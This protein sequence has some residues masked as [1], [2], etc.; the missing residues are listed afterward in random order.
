MSKYELF[1]DHWMFTTE[2]INTP[3][4]TVRKAAA[5]GGYTAAIEK[6]GENGEI[7]PLGQGGH[8]FLNLI[9]GGNEVRGLKMLAGTDFDAILAGWQSVTIPHDW[10]MT[11]PYV[12][13]PELLMSGSKPNG[14]AYYRKCF[15]LPKEYENKQIHVCFEGVMRAASVWLNGCFLGDHY[16]GYTGFSFD[17]SDLAH[18]GEEGDNILLVRVDTT[19]GS[20]GWWYDGAGI[21]RNVTLQVSEKLHIPQWGV[22]VRTEKLENEEAVVSIESTIVNKTYTQA[23]FQVKATLLHDGQVIGT[24]VSASETVASLEKIVLKQPVSIKHPKKWAIEKPNLYDVLVEVLVDHVVIDT[25]ETR[26]GLRTIDYTSEG[27]FINGVQTELKGVCEH[28]DFAGVGTALTKEIVRYK[29]ERLKEMGANAYRSAHHAA[30]IELLDLCDEMGILV[31]E[32][33]R[34]LESSDLRLLELEEMVIRD[35]NHPSIIFWSLCNEEVIGSTKMATRMAA[36]MAAVVRKLD[37]ERL[38]VSAEL[39]SPEGIVSE[40]YIQLF[41]VLGVN[42]PESPIMGNGLNEIHKRYPNQMVMSTENASFFSTRGIYQDD[43]DLCQTSNYGSCLSMFRK[44]PLPPDAPGAGGTAHPEQVMDFY[45][46]HPFMGGSFIWTAL[47]YCGEP[48]PFPW[49]AISSQFGIMDTCGFPKDYFYYYQSKWTKEPMVHIMPHWNFEGREGELI[50]I[51]VFTNCEAAELFVNDESQGIK[52][53]GHHSTSWEVPYASGE[54]N[55]IGYIQ[56]KEVV[57]QTK[58]TSGQ[59]VKLMAR[60]V[61][62]AVTVVADG[63]TAL[64]EIYAI[65][66]LGIEVPTADHLVKVTVQGGELKGIGNGNPMDH[67]PNLSAS[68]ALFSGKLL[69]VVTAKNHLADFRL[70]AENE[71]LETAVLVLNSLTLQ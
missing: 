33:N 10:K 70:Q 71:N 15:S 53:S 51:R 67:T 4:K 32:E 65:D 60:R 29:L 63:E 36:H 12:N 1:N 38:I 23:E 56:N 44:E 9:S 57:S 2:T 8:Y 58:K 62:S 5:I 28:Q 25:C 34:V 3:Y 21:Y 41:D 61:D 47:D 46:S 40:E 13:E 16:S 14:V 54:I 20:E 42:Y 11:L 24:C 48:A 68:R 31:I 18:Y 59:A 26:F 30:S 69:A 39:L 27:L 19:T 17:I 49:P 35:R 37:G 43:Y 50:E 64:I 22:H 66:A 45:E 52:D 55:V 6:E 7:V